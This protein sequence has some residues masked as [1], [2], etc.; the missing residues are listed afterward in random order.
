LAE[1]PATTEDQ[2]VCPICGSHD[3]EE[4]L[5]GWYPANDFDAGPSGELHLADLYHEKFWCK[6]CDDHVGWL[7]TEATK[8]EG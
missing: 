5:L 8:K 2:R 7:P 3:V 6:A 4:L 1:A